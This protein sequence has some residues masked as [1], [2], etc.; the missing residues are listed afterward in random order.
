[1]ALIPSARLVDW[2]PGTHVGVIG[3]IPARTDPSKVVNVLDFG[4]D[5]TGVSNAGT[6]V[7]AAIDSVANLVS[8]NYAVIYFPAGTYRFTNNPIIHYYNSQ[9]TLRGELG[10]TNADKLTVIKPEGTAFGFVIT[11]EQ[12]DTPTAVTSGLSKG[13]TTLVVADTSLISVGQCVE[14]QVANDYTVPTFARF[15]FDLADTGVS[16][17]KQLVR[18]TAVN[19]GTKTITFFP[20]LY[21]DYG[22]GSLQAQVVPNLHMVQGVGVEDM[23]ID[24]SVSQPAGRAVSFDFVYGCWMKNV[25]AHTTDNFM[26][27][28]NEALNCEVRDCDLWDV[29]HDGHALLIYENACA[30]LIENNSFW[31]AYPHIEMNQATMG[32]VVG[33]NYCKESGPGEHIDCHDAHPMYNLIE[34]N[35]FVHGA[36][37]RMT[38]F[39]HGSASRHTF[40][41]NVV[42]GFIGHRA[43]SR[44]MSSVGN[45]IDLGFSYGLPNGGNGDFSGYASLIGTVRPDTHVPADPWADWGTRLPQAGTVTITGSSCVATNSVFDVTMEAPSVG[46]P[47]GKGFW[48]DLI[49]G[50]NANRALQIITYISPTHV[51]LSDVSLN[52]TTPRAFKIVSG[53]GSAGNVGGFKELDLDVEASAI[54]KGNWNVADQSYSSLGGDTLPNSLYLSGAPGFFDGFTYPPINATTTQPSTFDSDGYDTILPAGARFNDFTPPTGGN[55]IVIQGVPTF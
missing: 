46:N 2:T 1:M 37:V 54:D 23:E 28:F 29:I 41:R 48:V 38:D 40:F 19:S 25:Y 34:G 42:E 50:P 22:S 31:S 36:G 35:V 16:I 55:A 21:D 5:N 15:G 4:A 49:A 20:P 43:F 14:V 18:V 12:Q 32:N 33:Y 26:V 27:S 3:G 13:A 17:Y 39:F 52:D 7:Q 44:D 30:G 47:N 53:V 9:I 8:P 45:I 11:S 51:T 24:Q 10:G 6:A